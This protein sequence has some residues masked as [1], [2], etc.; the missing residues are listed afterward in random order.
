MT[1]NSKNGKPLF[2]RWFKILWVVIIFA[3]FV[4][5]LLLGIFYSYFTHSDA[6]KTIASFAQYTYIGFFPV[7]VVAVMWVLAIVSL[8]AKYGYGR[9]I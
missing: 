8:V 7:V 9:K 3:G 4:M 6:Q 2:P 5:P 1:E